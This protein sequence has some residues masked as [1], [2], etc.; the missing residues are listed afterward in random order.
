MN[1]FLNNFKVSNKYLI[2]ATNLIPKEI[3]AVNTLA[4]IVVYQDKEDYSN[5]SEHLIKNLDFYDTK[6]KILF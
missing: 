4:S 6:S 2:Q 3:E 1:A 5:I